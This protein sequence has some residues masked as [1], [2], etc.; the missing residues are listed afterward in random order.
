MRAEPVIETLARTGE[1]LATGVR[2]RI[3]RYGLDGVLS[4]GGHPSWMLLRFS[5]QPSVRKEAIRTLFIRE[6]LRNG[7]LILGS[8]NVCYAHGANEVAHVLAAY[9]QSLGTIARALA[10]GNLPQVLGIPPIEPIF[11]VR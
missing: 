3:A 2:E 8:H 11:R 6:M 1:T 10:S 5:D 4:I 7:V 9:D